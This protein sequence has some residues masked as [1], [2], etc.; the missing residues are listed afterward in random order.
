MK[1]RGKVVVWDV[2][3]WDVVSHECASE[4]PLRSRDRQRRV[5][6]RPRCCV[7]SP[8]HA[9]CMHK[10]APRL[11]PPH[12]RAPAARAAPSGTRS[13]LSERRR[14][15]QRKAPKEFSVAPLRGRRARRNSDFDG[16]LR[17]SGCSRITA[18]QLTHTRRN[19]RTDRSVERVHVNRD[20]LRASKPD[21]CT[22][23]RNGGGRAQ[24]ER[25]RKPGYALH[26][27]Y[28]EK[29]RQLERS[30]RKRTP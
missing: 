21:S 10:E 2:A 26:R 9:H 18:R 8:N 29:L 5:E 15:L 20:E 4:L 27:G 19:P 6:A 13:S 14:V 7:P 12:P 22:E 25:R 24:P 1:Y 30:G 11:A 23:D 16:G 3:K 28:A 17:R